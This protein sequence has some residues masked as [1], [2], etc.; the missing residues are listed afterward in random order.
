MY[1]VE[2]KIALDGKSSSC[3]M[4]IHFTL[5]FSLRYCLEKLK[6]GPEK[7]FAKQYVLIFAFVSIN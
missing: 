4:L 5:F 3:N 1:I 2:L 6:F 7:V